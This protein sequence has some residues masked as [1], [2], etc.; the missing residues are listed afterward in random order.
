[1]E[2]DVNIAAMMSLDLDADISASVPVS[3]LLATSI[4]LLYLL[5]T[6]L[7]GQESWEKYGVK[8]I[9]LGR[10]ALQDSRVLVSTLIAQHGDTVGFNTGTMML[11]T[12]DLDLIRQIAAKDSNNFL[13]RLTLCVTRSAMESG[14]F[15]LGGKSWRRVRNV[16]TPSF[17]TGKLK[18]ACTNIEE[19]AQKLATV[20]EEFARNQTLLPV[21]HITSQYTSEIIARS[22]FGLRT[23]C[24]GKGDDEFTYCAKN[25][26]N[27]NG[28]IA[29]MIVH[30]VS[31]SKTLH[32]VL[33]KTLGVSLFDMVNKETDRYFH[34]LV[35]SLV[36]QRVELERQVTN[37]PTDLLQ[38]LVAAKLAGDTEAEDGGSH[39]QTW[40]KLPKT[41]SDRELLGQCILV[42]F[43]GF[44]TTATTLQMCLYLLAK[45]PDIQEKVHQEICSVVASDSPTY[46][47][48][49]QLTYLEQVI[50]ETLRLYPPIPLYR[51]VAAETK[52]Y[53]H[54]T[55]PKN[56]VVIVPLE[57]IMKDPR[58]YP[59]PHKFDPDRFSPENSKQRDPITF[60]PFGY[61]PRLCIGMRLAYLEL[62]IGLVHVLRKVRVELSELTEPQIGGGVSL[63]FQGF[64]VVEKPIQLEVKLR[65]NNTSK[66]D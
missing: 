46:E 48:L 5:Y 60:V 28:K 39:D 49:G 27:I 41:M 40:G 61:G 56:T 32:H 11:L 45:H 9:S 15:F 42:V 33:A 19:S 65:Q 8:H 21:K 20:L 6:N 43:A 13:D 31:R 57:E 1:M 34:T 18:Q 17:S 66:T 53:G 26:F 36:S 30:A 58:N 7:F 29:T 47:E 38:S 62:K 59:D 44:E 10:L 50:K 51:R 54:V 22:A 2:M 64:I 35:S 16:M 3:V 55:I 4:V 52:T 23:D 12:R 25:I 24:L 63:K 14:L 37:K